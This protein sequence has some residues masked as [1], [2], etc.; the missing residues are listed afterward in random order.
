MLDKNG[1]LVDKKIREI[2][3]NTYRTHIETLKTCPFN[4]ISDELWE[5]TEEYHF[6]SATINKSIDKINGMV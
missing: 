5:N 6:T 3:G 4:V 1:A 2:L